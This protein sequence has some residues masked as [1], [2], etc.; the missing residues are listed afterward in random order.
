MDLNLAC[1]LPKQYFMQLCSRSGLAKRGILVVAGIID[2]DYTGPI[3]ALIYNT[4]GTEYKI[5]KGD[6]VAQAV[7]L[8]Y[9]HGEFKERELEAI[10]RGASGFGS[11]GV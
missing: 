4:T 1:Q 8:K 10:G 2:R 11:K 6:R 5:H 3:Q 7:L 9:H